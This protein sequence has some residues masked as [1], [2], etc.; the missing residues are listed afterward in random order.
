MRCDPLP[1][2]AP[3]NHPL[4]SANC[5]ATGHAWATTAR[6]E[7]VNTE[8]VL[9]TPASFHGPKACWESVSLWVP[10]M[11]DYAPR[12]GA[13]LVPLVESQRSAM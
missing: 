11:A 9:N 6:A 8:S 4:P 13:N 10:M 2:W 12:L 5:L 3:A 7:E 1:V